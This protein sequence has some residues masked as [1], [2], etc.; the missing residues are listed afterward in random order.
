MDRAV[1]DQSS[2]NLHVW[3]PKKTV[4]ALAC[5]ENQCTPWLQLYWY[6]T[7]PNLLSLLLYWRRI[8]LL[9]G[10]RKLFLLVAFQ[11]G[12]S[13]LFQKFY[14][15]SLCDFWQMLDDLSRLGKLLRISLLNIKSWRE[16]EDKTDT[17][18]FLL[19]VPNLKFSWC[20]NV[21]FFIEAFYWLF[22]MVLVLGITIMEQWVVK[23]A[24]RRTQASGSSS[25][26]HW[27]V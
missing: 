1:A 11:S 17:K 9:R 16:E 24:L 21:S 27:K 18:M 8:L 12:L 23:T 6:A 15:C 3:K 14:I 4:L 20:S 22:E 25:R 19:R 5:I 2:W 7:L 26:L 10:K 13:V